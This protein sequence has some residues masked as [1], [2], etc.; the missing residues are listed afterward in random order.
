VMTPIAAEG[1]FSTNYRSGVIAD[2][3]MTF[4]N[5]AVEL[6]KNQSQWEKCQLR[7]IEIINTKFAKFKHNNRFRDKLHTILSDIATHRKNNFMGEIFKHHTLRSTKF[8]GKYI[9]EKNK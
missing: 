9:E 7:G 3:P 6:Y 8:L 2:D 4:A 1:I 5:Y